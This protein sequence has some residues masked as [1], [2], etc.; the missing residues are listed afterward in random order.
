MLFV[1]SSSG[2]CVCVVF[3]IFSTPGTVVVH[4]A[5]PFRSTNHSVARVDVIFAEAL[6]ESEGDVFTMD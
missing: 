2:C 4:C 3:F 1:F 5:V 6:N